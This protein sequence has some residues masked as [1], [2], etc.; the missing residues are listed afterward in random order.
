[1]MILLKNSNK[2]TVT[3]NY[4]FNSVNPMKPEPVNNFFSFLFILIL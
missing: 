3:E 2:K 4:A 1:M